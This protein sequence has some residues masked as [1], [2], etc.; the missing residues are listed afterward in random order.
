M[1]TA[2]RPLVS[3]VTIF[4][5][6]KEFFTQAIE[7]VLTQTYP[8]WEL[9]LVD[10]GST[11]GSSE[12]A[13]G[14]AAARPEQIRYVQHPGHGSRGMSASR[15]AGVRHARGT[16]VAFLDADDIWVPDKLAIQ[17]GLLDAHPAA[18]MVAG[19]TRIWY[20]WAGGGDDA[21]K[22]TI[23]HVSEPVDV[24]CPPPELLRRYLTDRALTPA[25]CGVLI[26]R[27]AIDRVGGF[28]E[29]FTGLYEDQAFFLKTYL[30]L[31]IYLTSTCTDWYRQHPHSH[32][33]EALRTGRYSAHQP[34]AALVGLFLWL[35][36][37]FVAH[38]VTDRALWRDLVRKL[39]RLGVHR[40]M[41]GVNRPIKAALAWWYRVKSPVPREEPRGHR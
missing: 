11:D 17:V 3:I 30:S 28:E 25:T 26:R 10:D 35:T 4:L 9:L 22:D 32:S 38:R 33:A 5:D 20:S 40:T 24:L 39:A 2:A 37:H 13:R 15:N 21:A 36:R 29:R 8:H 34:S 7:S 41:V 12:I 14:Y 6:A 16:L 1:S 19:R 18:D 27:D 23:R 31:P